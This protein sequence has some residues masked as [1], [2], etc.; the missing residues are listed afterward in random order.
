LTK[1]KN[2]EKIISMDG[3]NLFGALI[4]GTIGMTSF[5]IGKKRANAK[6]MIIGAVLMGYPYL[7]PDT[8]ILYIVGVFLTVALFLFR[9]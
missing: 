9:G 4:F 2:K 7:V 5:I 6:L 3:Y 8:L 1:R